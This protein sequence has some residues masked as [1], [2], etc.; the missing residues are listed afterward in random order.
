RVKYSTSALAE[1][2]FSY[3]YPA[4][5]AR[6]RERYALKKI[7]CQVEEQ[8]EQALAEMR[9]HREFS[10][11]NT[12]PL[13]DWALVVVEQGDAAY[14][15][16]PFMEVS[17]RELLNRRVMGPGP[18]I[19][20]V[21]ALRIFAGIC[22]GVRAL[23]H[24]NPPWAHRRPENIMIG[25]DGTP[26]I[27]DFGSVAP[28]ERTIRGR[29]DALSLQDEAAQFCTLPY[30]APELFDVA[31]DAILDARTDVWSLGC[32]LFALG[33]GLSPFECEFGPGGEARAVECSFLRVIGQV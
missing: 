16:F 6:T 31:S 21:E 3:V 18:P 29:T 2:G 5:N 22:R 23:H 33:I 30:R 12:M 19:G 10:H 11:P 26:V 24:H 8:R 28:A 7:L 9:A 1:G 14:L 15:L 13:L 27:M 17:L 32:V 20:E 4:Y 25:R